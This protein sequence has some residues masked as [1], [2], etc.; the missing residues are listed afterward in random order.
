MILVVDDEPR[1]V[2]AWVDELR[3]AF[4]RVEVCPS[5]SEALARIRAAGPGE[6][7]LLV[8]DL[9]MPVDDSLTDEETQYGTRT[10]LVVYK[11]FRERFPRT[12]AILLTNVRDDALFRDYEHKPH[13]HAGRK[14]ELLPTQL[15]EIARSLG[16]TG[17]APA[18][19]M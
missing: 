2:A 7:R 11:C 13:D 12:P 9:M 16:V 5:A 18:P 6:I 3:E 17:E 10:G 15:V 14:F 8:W 1:R 19:G 4:G